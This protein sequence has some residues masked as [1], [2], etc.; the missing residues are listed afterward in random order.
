MLLLA[1]AIFFSYPAP[2]DMPRAQAYLVGDSSAGMQLEDRY[3]RDDLWTS[4]AVLGRWEDEE[5]R[6]LTV[7]RLDTVPPKF[8][9]SAL[10][11]ESYSGEE[12]PIDPRK[13]LE[14]RDQAISKLSPVEIAAEPAKPRQ[15]LRGFKEILY[16]EGTNTSAIVCAFR[17][18]TSR[19]TVKAAG[20]SAN[21]AEEPWYLATWEL[22]EGDEREA[23][24]EIFEKEFLGDWEN[25]L[26]AYLRSEIPAGGQPAS[27]KLSER[28]LLRRDAH[29]SITN[30]VKWRSVDAAEFTILHCLP[31]ADTFMRTLTN[32]LSVMRRLYA[33]TIP[34]PLDGSNVLCVARIFADREDYLAAAGE[35]MEW[36]AAYW[37]ALRRELV[38]YLPDGGGGEL[39]RTIRHEAFHQYL[40]YAAS[41]ITSSP[42]INEGYAQYFEDVDS[43]DWKLSPASLQGPEKPGR[44]ELEAF[45]ELLP[46]VIGMDYAQFYAGDDAARRLK[47]RLAWS[48]AYFIENGAPEIRFQPFK[49]LK[50][51]YIAALIDT[52]D[53][54]EATVRA[55]KSKD[56]LDLFIAEWKRFWISL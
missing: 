11:R 46:A 8:S 41:M 7:S 17:R 47:Y 31:E 56:R 25:V 43:R 14:L 28:E 48:I 34:T 40:S 22:V 33:A 50:K 2:L 52:R 24:R 1:S 32:D 55:F 38:A 6:L 13:D 53:M 35:D 21:R 18:E 3:L 45:A 4:R 54:R 29:H 19:R 51:D 23:A 9:D 16:F 5:G 12:L 26:E 30:Y 27:A 15:N 42:W 37:N 39:L 44:E 20:G 10:T 49:D 36:S